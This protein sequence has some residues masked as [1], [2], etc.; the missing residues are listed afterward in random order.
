[1]FIKTHKTFILKSDWKVKNNRNFQNTFINFCED[2]IK[3]NNKNL[4]EWITYRRHNI[5]NN[6]SRIILRN[7]DFLAFKF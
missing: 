1:M 5:L 6:K 2:V 7:K 3:K 4:D